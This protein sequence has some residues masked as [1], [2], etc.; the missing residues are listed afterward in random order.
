MS[1]EEIRSSLELTGESFKMMEIPN[2]KDMLCS[3]WD[4]LLSVTKDLAVHV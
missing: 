2:M 3:I 4:E 1:E